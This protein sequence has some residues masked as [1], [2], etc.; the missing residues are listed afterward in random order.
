[1]VPDLG[2]DQPIGKKEKLNVKVLIYKSEHFKWF[3]NPLFELKIDLIY[4][5]GRLFFLFIT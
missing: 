4:K 3:D 5:E 1:M 2:I